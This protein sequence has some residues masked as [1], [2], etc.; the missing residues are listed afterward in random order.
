MLRAI[1][2]HIRFPTGHRC[3]S[4]SPTLAAI[5]VWRQHRQLFQHVSHALLLSHSSCQ[6]AGTTGGLHFYSMPCPTS[7]TSHTANIIC[8]SSLTPTYS[9]ASSQHSVLTDNAT[10]KEHV[11][12]YT[13]DVQ[14][15]VELEQ[16]YCCM[17]ISTCWYTYL[18][19]Y[20]L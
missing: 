9:K 11:Y 14:C 15:S 6:L 10:A 20:A 16:R 2:T 4:C 19:L 12:L 13:P 17:I 7:V 18:F 3:W 1:M 8:T 5:P